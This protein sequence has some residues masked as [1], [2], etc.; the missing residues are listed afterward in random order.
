MMGTGVINMFTLSI[1]LFREIK[2]LGINIEKQFF[3]ISEYLG[4][5]EVFTIK[6]HCKSLKQLTLTHSFPIFLFWS[7]RLVASSLTVESCRDSG[8]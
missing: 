8:S 6:N 4:R 1:N 2:N 7:S 5:T 3:Y